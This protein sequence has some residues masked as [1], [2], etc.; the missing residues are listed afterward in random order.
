MLVPDT[1]LGSLAGTAVHRGQ[2]CRIFYSRHGCYTAVPYVFRTW[3]YRD[4][5][6]W[7][8]RALIV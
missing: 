1:L 4:A 2:R 6:C 7:S 5:R 3:Y 8:F